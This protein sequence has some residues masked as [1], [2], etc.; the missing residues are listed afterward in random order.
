MSKSKGEFLRVK[1]LIDKG[2]SP[3]DYR[4]L[5]LGT[6]YRKR[7]L[8]SWELLDSAKTALS[9]LKNRIKTLKEELTTNSTND[10][11]SENKHKERF[12]EVINDDL[13]MPEALAVMWDTLRDE[14]I[15]P[16]GKLELINNFDKVL[17]LDLD[18]EVEEKN[19]DVPAEIMEMV[20]QRIA[21]KKAKD[22]KL[23]D[24]LRDK[25][26]DLGYEIV[27]KKDGVEVKEITN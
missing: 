3:M 23:A 17:G 25:V 7:L 9:R 21:A 24:E 6:H 16:A 19:T 22:F 18:K 1:T 20:N 15:S 27:D 10:T 8:F 12:N 14:N 13:N 5:C 11:N 4:Y 2:Y 26:K